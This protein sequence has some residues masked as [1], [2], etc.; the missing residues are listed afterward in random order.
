MSEQ[1]TAAIIGMPFELAMS[2]EVSRKQFHARAQRLL[3]ENERLATELSACTD[4]PGGC[5]YWREAARRREVERDDAEVRANYWKQRAKS[6][7]G[8]LFASDWREACRAL[9]KNT[10]MASTQWEELHPAYRARI[11]SAAASVIAVV[12]GRLNAR[13][14]A[15]HRGEEVSRHGQE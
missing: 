12:A 1:M 8:H 13:R 9:H 14:P 3:L 5:G 4:S 2:S 6:A 11:E 10:P 7:E 15:P